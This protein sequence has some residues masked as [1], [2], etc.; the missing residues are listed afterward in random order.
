MKHILCI[1]VG[2][3]SVHCGIISQGNVLQKWRLDT[4]GLTMSDM[5]ASLANIHFDGA[6]VGSVVPHITGIICDSLAQCDVPVVRYGDTGITTGINVPFAHA[7]DVGADIILNGMASQ[8][9]YQ[10]NTIIL[11]FGTATTFD[12]FTHAQEFCGTVIAPGVDVSL[13]A[14]Y[15]KTAQLPRVDVAPTPDVVCTTTK[16]CMQSGIFWGY[17]SLIEGVLARIHMQYKD[18]TRFGHQPTHVIATGGLAPLFKDYTDCIDII[19]SDL[20]LIGLGLLYERNI[21]D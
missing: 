15:E 6:C 14:L 2:N 13:Q 4:Y 18:D 16:D 3:T 19:H 11:D 7:R 10:G 17:L 9:L 12:V 21:N 5:L 20:T 1:D 8:S